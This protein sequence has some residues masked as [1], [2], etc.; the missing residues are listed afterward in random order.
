MVLW[1]GVLTHS[2]VGVGTVVGSELFN[3]LCIIGAV[4]LVTPRPLQMDWRPL[5]REVVFFAI[6]LIMLLWVLNDE[7]VETREAS[8]LLAGYLVRLDTPSHQ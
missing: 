1:A 3:L 6:S 8:M 7:K 2:A 5:S 4:C